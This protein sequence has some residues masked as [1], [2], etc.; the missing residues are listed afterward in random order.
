[1]RKVDEAEE[2]LVDDFIAKGCG[3]SLGPGI[4]CSKLFHRDVFLATRMSCL[5]MSTT[6]LDI[7]HLDAHRS[8]G[9]GSTSI[10]SAGQQSAKSRVNI[11]YYFR[12]YQ[13]CKKTYTFL[14]AVGPKRFKNLV[15]HFE[16]NGLVPRVHGNTKHL[17]ANTTP[18]KNTKAVVSF[19]ENFAAIHALPVPGR[20]PG[21]YTDQKPF[22]CLH[23]CQRDMSTGSTA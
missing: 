8:C 13:V 20:L 21:Q 22:C 1:M 9:N 18:L 16:Q 11:L 23:T 7:G 17:P 5:K 3:C 2:R 14:H 12:G 6:E 10:K 15:A 19:I 4:P